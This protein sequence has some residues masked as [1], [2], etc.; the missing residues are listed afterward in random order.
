M[1]EIIIVVIM[2]LCYLTLLDH[3]DKLYAN[4]Y[5]YEKK[6]KKQHA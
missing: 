5:F 2:K 1:F 3:K 4:I 6:N